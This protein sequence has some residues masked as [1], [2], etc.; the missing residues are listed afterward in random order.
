[1]ECSRVRFRHLCCCRWLRLTEV[2]DRRSIMS[3]DFSFGAVM[4]QAVGVG[5]LKNWVVS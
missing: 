2:F 3:L 1:M 4:T 5:T